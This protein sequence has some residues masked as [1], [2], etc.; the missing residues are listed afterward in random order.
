MG[1]QSTLS[2]L[3][4]IQRKDSGDRCARK[5]KPSSHIGSGNEITVHNRKNKNKNSYDA[6][7][8]AAYAAEVVV[9]LIQQ[10]SYPIAING[11][12]DSSFLCAELA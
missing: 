9:F 4:H 6:R 12:V 3:K 5:Y 1:K 8:C 7:L 11:G 10:R 2:G